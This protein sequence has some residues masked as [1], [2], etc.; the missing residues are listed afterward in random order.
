MADM[1]NQFPGVKNR[2]D[3]LQFNVSTLQTQT[4]Q[5]GLLVWEIDENGDLMPPAKI[6][7]NMK[8]E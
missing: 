2:I 3:T 1:L 4:G 5:M 8:W 6:T 7:N